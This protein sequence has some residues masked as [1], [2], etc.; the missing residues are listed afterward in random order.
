MSSTK[1]TQIKEIALKKII[2]NFV[3]ITLV[4]IFIFSVL[5]ASEKETEDVKK[6]IIDAYIK[7]I[8]TIGDADMVK[9]GWHEECD[10]VIFTDGKLR[11]LPAKFWV[12]RLTKNPGPITKDATYKF[13]DVR[14][15]DYAAIAVL[16]VYYSGKH[17]Y[18]DYMSLYKF[19]D[20]WKI[21]T[22][23]YYEPP[24]DA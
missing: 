6:V 20:G 23:I 19:S 5:S 16:E 1:L 15:T 2:L 3:L 17:K 9:K 11:K 4:T 12:D 7:G 18:T 22:K 10:I 8:I 13:L 14:I 21:V 24:F